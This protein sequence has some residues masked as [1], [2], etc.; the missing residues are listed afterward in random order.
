MPNM[1]TWYHEVATAFV[2]PSDNSVYVFTDDARV[3]R[4][5]LV[6]EALQKWTGPLPAVNVNHLLNSDVFIRCG[7][8]LNPPVRNVD[9]CGTWTPSK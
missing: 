9:C 8:G 1:G 4:P 7:G 5:L 3:V 2:N 6:V